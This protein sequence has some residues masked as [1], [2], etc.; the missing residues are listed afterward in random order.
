MA[1]GFILL[2]GQRRAP[3]AIALMWALVAQ[4]RGSL[5]PLD[6]VVCV[7]EFSRARW[8]TWR[9]RFGADLPARIASGI[10]L[11]T[12]SQHDDE[13][14][15]WEERLGAR[16]IP[17]RNLKPLCAEFAVPLH[18]VDSLNSQKALRLVKRYQPQWALFTGGGIVRKG[19]LDALPGGILNIHSAWL[20]HVRG[21][22]AA[23]WSLFHGF[24]PA[25]T[26]HLM[27]RG[28]DTG[29]IL[30]QRPIDVP[31]GEAIGRTRGR[32][33]VAGL[34]L[35]LE[36][37]PEVA[38]GRLEPQEN[39]RD[40]GRQYYIMSPALKQIVQGW[41]DAGITPVAAPDTID[42]DDLRAAPERHA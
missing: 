7:S 17:H 38:A 12:W 1:K 36:I 10:G 32:V 30:A 31:K 35:L 29:P 14:A 5:P 26:V 37:L 42:P 33:V 4:D 6:A 18:F 20:P 28:V 9:R 11:R 25:A 40:K 15:V 22:N 41:V 2:A 21:M 13:R 19:L 16:D 27:D 8:R 3:T 39:P 24:N 23:E 34:D